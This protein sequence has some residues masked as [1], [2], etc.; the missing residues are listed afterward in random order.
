MER[1]LIWVIICIVLMDKPLQSNNY[2][3]NK[4]PC[5]SDYASCY[6]APLDD[7]LSS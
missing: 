6:C 1:S 7:I 4:Y 3:D 5:Y 2:S